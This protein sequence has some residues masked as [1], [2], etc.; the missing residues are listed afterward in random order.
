MRAAAIPNTQALLS[1]LRAHQPRWAD[2]FHLPDQSDV[3]VWVELEALLQRPVDL[4]RLRERMNPA[5]RQET[6]GAHTTAAGEAIWRQIDSV[7]ALLYVK[8][9]ADRTRRPHHS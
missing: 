5:L 8:A 1:L 2:R 4:M 6:A 9:V 7:V 3:D